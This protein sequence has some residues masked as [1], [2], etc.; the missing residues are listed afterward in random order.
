MMLA[1][2]QVCDFGMSRAMELKSRITTKT[3]GTL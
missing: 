1:P 2:L 3:Y